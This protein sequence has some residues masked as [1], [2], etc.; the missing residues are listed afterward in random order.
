MQVVAAAEQVI[1]GLIR[2]SE[3]EVV[4]A[5]RL[6][7]GKPGLLVVAAQH[8]DV[9]RHMVHVA[10]IGAHPA[11][12]VRRA[13][14]ALRHSGHFQQMDMQMEDRRVRRDAGLVGEADRPLAN[15][16]RLDNVRIRRRRARLEVPEAPHAAHHQRLDK[17]RHHVVVVGKAGVD[18]PHLGGVGVIPLLEFLRRHAMRFLETVGKRLDQSPFD[19]TG[20]SGAG[21]RKLDMLE[22]AP[23]RAVGLGVAMFLPGQIVEG[24]GGVSD[25]P[26]HHGAS[27]IAFQRLL[28]ALDAFFVVEA[29][30]PV[31]AD[32]EPALGFRRAGGDGAPIGAKVEAIHASFFSSHSWRPARPPFRIKAYVRFRFPGSPFRIRGR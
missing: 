22:A 6:F 5:I 31:Q 11:E 27:G 15:L 20:V 12:P 28:E 4:G 25:T 21:A 8:V 14:A 17:Q 30:A 18:R 2:I 9:A 29:V 1:G 26:M 7:A 10:G 3:I 19:R 13:H 24:P 23:G 32:I 16:Q